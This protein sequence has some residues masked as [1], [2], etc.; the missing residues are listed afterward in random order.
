MNTGLTGKSAIGRNGAVNG[1]EMVPLV[2][3]GASGSPREEGTSVATSNEGNILTFRGS[4]QFNDS[5]NRDSMQTDRQIIHQQTTFGN[6][7]TARGKPSP[8]TGSA[9][10]SSHAL[11]ASTH[12]NLVQTQQLILS[13]NGVAG[14]GSV[15]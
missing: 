13:G 15:H 8:G 4:R 5:S 6:I 10:I 7:A 12:P 14:M 2:G 1:P 3:Q 9:E 11:I